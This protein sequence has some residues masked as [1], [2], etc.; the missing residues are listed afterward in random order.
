MATKRDYYEVLG[1]ERTATVEEIKGAYR[2]MAKRYHPDRNPGDA[3]AE[4]RFKEAA[5][6]YEVLSDQDKRT[7]YDRHG[8]AGLEGAGVHD[9][10]NASAADVFSMFG[11][12]FGSSLFEDFLRPA[13]AGRGPR[14][15]A[16]V[17]TRLDITL[18]EAVRGVTKPIEVRR[19]EI[20]EDCRGSGARKGSKPVVCS[21]CGGRG[22]VVHSRGFF[23]VAATCQSC[24]GDGVRVN[25][26]CATCRGSGHVSVASTL[27]V[28]VPAGVDT[29]MWLQYRRQ[30]DAG[31]LGADRGDLRIQVHVKPHPFFSRQGL[32]LHT[33][34]PI[35][36]PQAALG[37]EINVPTL[38]ATE[39]LQI[40]PGTQSGEIFRLKG[41]GVP[42]YK[43]QRGRGDLLVEIVVE[44][45]RELTPRQEELIRELAELDHEHVSPRRKSF[46]EKLRDFFTTEDETH[47]HHHHHPKH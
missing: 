24:G 25:D 40:H 30:G 3:E 7:R 19:A 35:G 44:I 21:Y 31:D 20:C 43:S 15:G 13:G 41:R 29:G 36:F 39:K 37:G 8:H 33:Q 16:D 27:N 32:D 6:A 1:V 38:D 23:Q 9:F 42:D 26:P 2:V 12:I 17:V 18:E 11:E 34:V 14:R 5:E 22:Q 4:L 46:L 45:P 28:D 47:H 10:R